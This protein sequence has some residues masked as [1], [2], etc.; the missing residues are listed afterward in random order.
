MADNVAPDVA[1]TLDHHSRS[2]NTTDTQ[3]AVRPNEGGRVDGNI[4][5]DHRSRM[6][7]GSK[8]L[9]GEEQ[10]KDPGEGDAWIGDADEGLGGG[11]KF[12]RNQDRCGGTHFRPG[13]VIV[14]FGERQITRFGPFG[15]G[16][17]CELSVRITRYFPL[18]V[19]GNFGGG[20][21]HLMN[22]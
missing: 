10:G 20:I 4:R 1:S 6:D 3:H 11:G 5:G 8:N 16:E 7:R 15:R 19:G 13:E 14:V 12:E 2:D 18:Q 17:T 21:K 9:W 22:S